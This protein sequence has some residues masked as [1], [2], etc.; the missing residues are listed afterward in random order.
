MVLAAVGM[1]A[2]H[3]L[4]AG[5]VT[6]ESPEVREIVE[7]ALGYLESQTDPR[8]GAKCLIGLAFHKAGRPDDHPQI[9][10]AVEACRTM[11]A[12]ERDFSYIYSKALAA[13]FLAEIDASQHR[14]LI[15]TYASMLPEHIKPGGGYGYSAFNDPLGDTSQTQYAALCI[16]ELLRIGMRP[17]VQ[18]VEACTNWLLRTQDPSGTWGYKGKDPGDFSG[19]EQELT[20]ACMLAA[21]LGSTL[22]CGNMLGILSPGGAPSLEIERT[23]AEESTGV[24]SA[25]RR[26][27]ARQQR[28]LPRLS[29][30]G[31]VSPERLQQSITRGKAWFNKNFT[32]T[33]NG[34]YVCYYLY[35]LERYKSFEAYIEADANE[36]PDWYQAGYELLKKNQ[37]PDGHWDFTGESAGTPCA[38]SFAV[39]FLLRST[40]QSINASLG[41]GTLVG[42]RGLPRDLSKLRLRGS[43]LVVQQKP[44]EI[45]SLLDLLGSDD[46]GGLDA[47]LDNP[48]AL[49]V[50][51]VGPDEAR[52]LQQIVRGGKPEA[53]LLA[54]RALS[55]MR[56]LDY[57]PTLIFA[58]TDPDR[59][60]VRE[61]R[62][63]LRYVS[64]RFTG[65]GLPDNFDDDRVRDQVVDKWKNW[66]RSVRPDAPPL[67]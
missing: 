35:S 5:A 61:A 34:R 21:G 8:L 54:V 10:A 51:E 27:D 66:Y 39:L 22:I 56:N 60:V 2:G 25:L 13:I 45:D 36:E 63:G 3:A 7:K 46:D 67:P 19:T 47:L 29:A 62:D 52:R 15:E 40:Q 37:R 42:G 65:F 12:A 17:D 43:K 64:R 30:T 41:E 26:A 32:I 4:T 9:Q 59:R 6:S 20:S 18:Q 44:T 53:R 50:G 31:A 58:L 57:A 14:S 55:R 24:P 49:E 28:Q 11:A 1:S 48:A 33:N 16:W 23:S 38:T